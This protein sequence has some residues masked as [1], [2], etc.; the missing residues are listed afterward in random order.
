M[1]LAL[2]CFSWELNTA[3]VK[4]DPSKISTWH[5][6]TTTPLEKLAPGPS[7]PLFWNDSILNN[8]PILASYPIYSH[9]ICWRLARRQEEARPIVSYFSMKINE[10]DYI[11]KYSRPSTHAPTILKLKHTTNNYN[12]LSQALFHLLN[13]LTYFIKIYIY[14]YT[15]VIYLILYHTSICV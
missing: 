13:I 4:C 8:V 10:Y 9:H 6:R 5:P 15:V 14:Y 2:Q 3:E 7:Y 12:Y 1:F 11:F